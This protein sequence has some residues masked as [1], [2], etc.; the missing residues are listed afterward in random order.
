MWGS[1]E[2]FA[3]PQGVS[4]QVLLGLF[5]SFLASFSLLAPGLWSRLFGCCLGYVSCFPNGSV[6]RQAENDHPVQSVPHCR[7]YMYKTSELSPG[8][9]RL[10][11]CLCNRAEP[12]FILYFTKINWS[13]VKEASLKWTS[14]GQN[15]QTVISVFV[16]AVQ[17]SFQVA[18]E[19][20]ICVFCIF[21]Q[22]SLTQ[23]SSGLVFGT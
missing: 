14:R 19:V 13:H 3:E 11:W 16:E 22:L 12:R 6:S 1:S 8:E 5:L 20:K 15:D 4:Q 2:E 7:I 21:K 17:V 18:C 23:Y 9:K 10:D